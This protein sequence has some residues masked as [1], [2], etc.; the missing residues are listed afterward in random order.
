MW[1]TISSENELSA[2]LET[3]CYFHDSCLKEMK[4]ISGAYVTEKLS[5]LPENNRRALSVV[6]QRQFGDIPMIEMEFEGLKY[7]KLFPVD[8]RYTCEILDATMIMKEGYIY[9]CDWGGLSET[10]IGS[11]DGTVICAAKLRWRAISGHMGQ[12]EFYRSIT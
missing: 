12:E 2:F 5:M 4:Y 7:L 10:D 8:E 6:I 3:V 11:Y 9:W 1:N